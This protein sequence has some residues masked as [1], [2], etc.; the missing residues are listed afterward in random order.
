M[1]RRQVINIKCLTFKR[2]HRGICTVGSDVLYTEGSF[3]SFFYSTHS[4]FPQGS[5]F[6]V[7]V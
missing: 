4:E 2:E 1:E 7:T 6:L 3:F 5:M